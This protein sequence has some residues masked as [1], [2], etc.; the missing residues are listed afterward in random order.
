MGYVIV[1]FI[2]LFTYMGMPKHVKLMF[3]LANF[4][5][6]DPLPF[7]DETIMVALF[8]KD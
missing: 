6:P 5:V 7:V 4:F 3:M 1:F 8:L 2:A